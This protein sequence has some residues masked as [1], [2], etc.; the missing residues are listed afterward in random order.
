MQRKRPLAPKPGQEHRLWLFLRSLK[1]EGWQFRKASPYRSF[2][3][4][5][6]AHDALLVIDISERG[7]IVRDRLLREAGYT[8]LRFAPSDSLDSMRTTIRAVLK[9]RLETET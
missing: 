6:V 5:F 4:P 1:D 7:N 8:I 3:L 2:L 9:D